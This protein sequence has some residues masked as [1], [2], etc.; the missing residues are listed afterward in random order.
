[1]RYP[2]RNLLGL[3]IAALLTAATVATAAA[4]PDTR[5]M[6]CE[7]TQRLIVRNGAVVLTTGAHTYDRYVAGYGYCSYP[8]EPTQTFVRTRDTSHCPVLNCQ[9]SEPP[10]FDK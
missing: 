7:Q 5:N 9:Y 1:M 2:A 10:I 4:R 8:D 3:G 6:S